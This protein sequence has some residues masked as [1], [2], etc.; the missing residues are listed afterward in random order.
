[1]NSLIAQDPPTLYTNHMNTCVTAHTVLIR[2]THIGLHIPLTHK[3]S[4]VLFHTHHNI[5]Y[6]ETFLTAYQPLPLCKHM[7]CQMF[8]YVHSS[9]QYTYA[10][11]YKPRLY[12]YPQHMPSKCQQDTYTLHLLQLGTHR[13]CMYT[14]IYMPLTQHVCAHLLTRHSHPFHKLSFTS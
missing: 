10:S 2:H 4:Y 7:I 13:A 9:P 11:C 8:T 5:D 3:Y 12:F 1:M 6:T 14:P